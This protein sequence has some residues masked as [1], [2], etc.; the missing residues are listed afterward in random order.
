M[1]VVKVLGLESLR[2]M[3]SAI[4]RGNGGLLLEYGLAG[5]SRLYLFVADSHVIQS[6]A[7]R[8]ADGESV[9]QALCFTPIANQL[10]EMWH[11]PAQ[12][13]CGGTGWGTCSSYLLLKNF[14]KRIKI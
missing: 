5:L 1:G 13:T 3:M 11:L 2:I 10:A 12:N 4:L 14:L 9:L 6:E 8:K 7:Q